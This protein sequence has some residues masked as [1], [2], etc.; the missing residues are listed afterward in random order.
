MQVVP[1]FRGGSRAERAVSPPSS[2][3]KFFRDF[4][5]Q[6]R[7]LFVYLPPRIRFSGIILLLVSS[8]FLLLFDL[9][10]QECGVIAEA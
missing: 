10:H 5:P 6:A 2:F 1:C 4:S 9:N 8:A 3:T 7:I